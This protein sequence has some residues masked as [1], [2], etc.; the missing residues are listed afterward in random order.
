MTINIIS[1]VKV[2]VALIALLLFTGC[3]SATRKNEPLAETVAKKEAVRR[4][5]RQVECDQCSFHD[6]Y[7]WVHVY[8]RP[9]TVANADAWVKVS[10]SG[11][12]V[13]FSVNKQ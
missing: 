5:W 2:H 4:G 8:R 7:W 10:I 13:D 3:S 1:I 6:G 9:L 11:S 12:L